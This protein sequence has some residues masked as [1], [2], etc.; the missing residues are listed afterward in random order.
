[1]TLH[2]HTISILQD[3]YAYVIQSGRQCAVIDPG[4]AKPIVTFLTDHVLTPD[5]IINTHKHSDH[6]GGNNELREVYPDCKL[7][8]PAECGASDYE[9]QD[10]SIF[11]LDVTCFHIYETKGHTNGHII[12][13]DGDSKTLFTGDTLFVMGC[14][15]LFEGT[16]EDMFKAMTLIKTFPPETKIYCGHEYTKANAKFARY[17]L[18]DSKVITAR[19]DDVMRTGVNVPTTLAQ[20]LKTNPFLIAETIED[21]ATY[22]RKKDNF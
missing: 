15:R 21:L 11:E 7:A 13:Y 17:I 18:P 3:N 10:G 9:L 8:A 22:R 5:W 4:E 20:E 14:G 6:V 2:V 1:M 16:P 19:Y 12:L